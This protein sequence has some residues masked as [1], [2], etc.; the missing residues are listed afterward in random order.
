MDEISTNSSQNKSPLNSSADNTQNIFMIK[1]L[2][3]DDII[4]N[5]KIKKL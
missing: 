2:N 1:I 3:K 4:I 5:N